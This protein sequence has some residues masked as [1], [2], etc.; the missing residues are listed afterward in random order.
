MSKNLPVISYSHEELVV[1][2]NSAS[3]SKMFADTKFTSKPEVTNVETPNLKSFTK[4]LGLNFTK[5][6]GNFM[7]YNKSVLTWSF[8]EFGHLKLN[9]NDHCEIFD[10]IVD[11]ESVM[12]F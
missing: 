1:K 10:F 12:R 6:K 4:K 9:E 2:D 7:V 8:A 5:N 3:N 11:P